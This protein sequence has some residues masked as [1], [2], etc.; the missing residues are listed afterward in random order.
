VGIDW[1]R[2]RPRP[3][4]ARERLAALVAEQALA[5]LQLPSFWSADL[6]PGT[7]LPEED[8]AVLDAYQR[9]SR[10]LAELLEM[11]DY[12][13]TDI[14]DLDPRFRVYPIAGCEVFPP[15]SRLGAYRSFLP[16]ELL[17]QLGRWRGWLDR[18][19]QG[20]AEGYLCRL[21]A[22]ETSLTWWQHATALRHALD[23]AVK[24]P[25]AP[26]DAAK[27]REAC[28]RVRACPEM[29]PLPAPALPPY[30]PA[31][32]PASAEDLALQAQCWKEA[33]ELVALSEA[34]DAAV[35]EPWQ[36][37]VDRA[38]YASPEQFRNEA[39]GPWLGEFL[40]WAQRCC[41]AGCGLF[42]DY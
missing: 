31:D 9:S 22:Y 32:E 28:E 26:S 16:D 25:D 4:A 19:R 2:M 41:D 36:V 40:N 37:R 33:G 11:P 35:E 15:Q 12:P 1:Y 34:W 6:L 30:G 17:A 20:T 24:R 39:N 3:G 23:G 5:L 27:F 10:E 18:V 8:P 38:Y 13:P 7:P 21:Y 29:L 14:P 42:L